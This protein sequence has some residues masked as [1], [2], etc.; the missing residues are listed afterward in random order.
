M[1]LPNRADL[2]ELI[3]KCQETKEID[4][5]AVMLQYLNRL[6]PLEYKIRLP[7]LI[8]NNWIDNCLYSLEEKFV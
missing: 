5:R 4:K 8:T 1:I 6:L 2:L 7:Y 3:R